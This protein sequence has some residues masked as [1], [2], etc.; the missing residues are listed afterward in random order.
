MIF[1]A[2]IRKNTQLIR[3]AD[4]ARD[5][6]KYHKAALSYERALRL[7]PDN[8][9]IHV[10]CGHMFNEAGDLIRAEHHYNQAKRLT[11]NDPDLALQ[12][13]HFYKVAGRPQETEVAYWRAIDL[14][15][16]WPEPAIQ[17]ADLYRAGWRAHTEGRCR[18]AERPRRFGCSRFG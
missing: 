13:G 7:E 3:D 14:A 12:F 16:D 9:A 15:P 17:L 6:K 10:Q 4:A 2:G 8:A 18:P 1:R 5:A 11:P